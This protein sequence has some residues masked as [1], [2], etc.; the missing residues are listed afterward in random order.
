[1]NFCNICGEHKP[2]KR[3]IVEGHGYCPN[4]C[5]DCLHTGNSIP[6]DG[7]FNRDRGREDFAKEVLQPFDSNGNINR[8]FAEAYQP[9]A[10]DMFGKERLQDI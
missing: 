9:Q 1:M 6:R 10:E 3:G 7:K 5:D 2:T 4:V 8:D